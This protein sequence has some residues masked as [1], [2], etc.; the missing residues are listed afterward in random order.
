MTNTCDAIVLGL[1]GFGSGALYHLARRGARVL[2]IERFGIAHDRGSSHGQ[3]RIIRKAYFEHPDYVPLL[4]R[5]YDLWH[6]LERETGRML[7]HPVGLFIAGDP[8]CESVAGTTLAAQLHHLPV[9]RL[10]ARA[11]RLRF[12]GYRFHD[13]FAVVFEPEAGYLEVE[14]C[15]SAHVAAAVRHGAML[16]IGE[17]V[18]GWSSDGRSV[19]VTTDRGTYSA[20]SLVITAGPWAGQVLGGAGSAPGAPAWSETLR[21]VRKPVFWFAAQKEYDVDQGNSTFFFETPEGQFYGFPRLDGK[22]IKLAEHTGGEEVRDPLTV[23]RGLHP[24]DLTRVSAFAR[25]FLPGIDP[26]PVTH[27]VCMYTKTPDSHFCIDRHPVLKN[28]VVGA[29]FSGHGFKFTTVLGEALADL[30][31]TGQTNLPVGFLSI[32]RFEQPSAAQQK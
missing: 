13:N 6:E 25:E 8:A 3:T 22:T 16:R 12:P 2:G 24:A 18:S 7:L 26:E 21:V 29:G 9:E 11:A 20:A 10:D 32:S 19:T 17:T 28:V 23:D 27:S 14:N 15:V 4:H 30:A 31:L 1:G 5:A